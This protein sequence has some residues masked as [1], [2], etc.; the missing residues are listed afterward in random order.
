MNLVE[1]T[2][3]DSGIIVY[4]GSSVAVCNWCECGENQMPAF[5][6]L[7]G[8]QLAWD[9]SE[10]VFD[11]VVSHRFSDVR[12]ELPGKI[13]LTGETDEDGNQLVETD[14]DI[15]S[16]Q[17]NDLLRLFMGQELDGSGTELTADDYEGTSYALQDGR[18]ILVLD[19]WN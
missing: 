2:N 1:L 19:V 15:V 18:K 10:D 17:F 5:G 8:M 6:P 12:E 11:G 4:D 16:D 7:P 9:E 14:L 13:W 3:H